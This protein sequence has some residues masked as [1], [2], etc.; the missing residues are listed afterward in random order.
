MKSYKAANMSTDYTFTGWLSESPESAAGKMVWKEYQ[1]KTWEETDIDIEVTH[2]GICGSD[3][4]IGARR[5]I[6]EMLELTAKKGVKPWIEKR[7]LEGANQAVL[8][9]AAI[10]QDSDTC[11]SMRSMRRCEQ[12]EW[13]V[14]LP[15]EGDY[16]YTA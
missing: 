5:E 8:D 10:S 4:H 2:C 7:K 12:E 11:W 9:M 16:E 3:L 1:P 14:Q 6:E 15:R 13:G